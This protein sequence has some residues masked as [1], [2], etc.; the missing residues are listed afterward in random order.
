MPTIVEPSLDA[1][2]STTNKPDE[3]INS[4]MAFRFCNFSSKGYTIRT[5]Q[6]CKKCHHRNGLDCKKKIYRVA[7]GCHNI[8]TTEGCARGKASWQS[9]HSEFLIESRWFVV[10]V[11]NNDDRLA[12]SCSDSNGNWKEVRQRTNQMNQ[13]TRTWRSEPRSR[14]HVQCHAL[15][16]NNSGCCP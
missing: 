6:C 15:V 4:N 14:S 13:S 7:V 5:D 8:E 12:V 1:V 3:S 2:S 10:D 16:I 9:T 11:F